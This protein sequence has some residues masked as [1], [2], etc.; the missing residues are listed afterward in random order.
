MHRLREFLP[1]VL[2]ALVMQILA[3]VAAC[4]A[5]GIA[6]ADPLQSVGICHSDASTNSGDQGREQYAHDGLCAICVA[7]AGAA[8]DAPKP[9]ALIHL[10]R[11]FRPVLWADAG[12]T[13]APSRIGSNTQARAPPRLA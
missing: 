10:A 2:L 7:H 4:W 13:L 8:V 6:A 1:I 12:L 3:P 11:P 5:T 9:V